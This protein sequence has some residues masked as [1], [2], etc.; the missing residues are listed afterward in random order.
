MN[1]LDLINSV[2]FRGAMK[3]PLAGSQVYEDFKKDTEFTGDFKC[4][5]KR[6]IIF[7]KNRSYKFTVRLAHINGE[8]FDETE[9]SFPNETFNKEQLTQL[10]KQLTNEQINEVNSKYVDLV[11][12][13]ILI[14]LV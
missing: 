5:K 1:T 8:D 6:N 14:E 4:P 11:N 13:Y 3:F 9:Y 12:S 7:S 2:I 10:M